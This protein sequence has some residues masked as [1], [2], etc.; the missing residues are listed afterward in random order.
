[1]ARCTTLVGVIPYQR[2]DWLRVLVAPHGSLSPGVMYRVVAFGAIAMAAWYLDREGASVRLPIGLHEIIGAIIAL[3][4]A[5]R[6]N[7]AYNRFWEGRTLWGAIVNSCR[8]VTRIVEQHARVDPDEM[9]V[10]A[11][12]VALFAH[13]TRRRLRQQPLEE[14]SRLLGDQGEA[15]ANA[16]H[17]ALAVSNELSRRVAAL[18]ASGNLDRMMATQAEAQIVALV[19]YLGGCERISSAPTPLGYVLLMRRCIALFLATSPW[20]LVEQLGGYTPILTVM[21]AYIVLMLEAL[22][23]ELDD[24]FG[25]DPNDLALTRICAVIERNT[26]GTEPPPAQPVR[27]VT[28]D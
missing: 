16:K 20:A 18:A 7:T 25:Q 8:N 2:R 21:I 4:L 11:A 27:R 28:E 1:M 3:I 13:A 14:A 17:P 10:F 12:Y 22:A 23:N 5:L 9:R 6:T 15:I 24:P 26:V 19:D